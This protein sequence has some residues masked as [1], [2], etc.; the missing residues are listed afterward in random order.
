MDVEQK[1]V[2]MDGDRSVCSSEDFFGIINRVKG[3]KIPYVFM[4]YLFE[5][6]SISSL[7]KL[8]WLELYSSAYGNGD[9]SV[10]VSIKWLGRKVGRGKEATRMA[11]N[12]LVRSGYV[13]ILSSGKNKK[14][15]NDILIRFPA[16]AIKEILGTGMSEKAMLL[17]EL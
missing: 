9:I 8:I 16:K 10:R 17:D 14:M 11:L 15:K 13:Q 7:S 1:S 6:N 2:D 5:D 4:S 12:N 3:R